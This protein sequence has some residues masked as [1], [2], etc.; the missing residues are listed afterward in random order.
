MIMFNRKNELN[1]NGVDPDQTP[2]SAA[3]D[4]DLNC[5]PTPLLWEASHKWVKLPLVY[6]MTEPYP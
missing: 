5:S 2:R 4:L 3:S 6:K 1:A